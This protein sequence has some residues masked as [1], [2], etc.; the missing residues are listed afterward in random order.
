MFFIKV[1]FPTPYS[2]HIFKPFASQFSSIQLNC[3]PIVEFNVFEVEFNV[4]IESKSIKYEFND[5]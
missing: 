2:Q 5:F 1:F 3:N 4:E